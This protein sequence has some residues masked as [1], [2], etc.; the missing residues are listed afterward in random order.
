MGLTD[1]ELPNE[2]V[3]MTHLVADYFLVD[4]EDVNVFTGDHE[5]LDSDAFVIVFEGGEI[6]GTPWT[7]NGQ[8]RERISLIGFASYWAEAVNSC[9][10][11]IHPNN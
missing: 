9:A 6:E 11:A 10:L 5:R 7:Q 1:Q 8:I 4:R 3:A 2:V